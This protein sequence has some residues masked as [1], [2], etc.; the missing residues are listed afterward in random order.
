MPLQILSSPSMMMEDNSTNNVSTARSPEHI[1]EEIP[2]VKATY[3]AVCVHD[4]DS[5]TEEHEAIFFAL[6]DRDP[7]AARNALRR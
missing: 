5:R 1:Y 2:E 4:A 6:R 3:E 7:A